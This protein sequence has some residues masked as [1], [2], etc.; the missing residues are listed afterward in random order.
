LD[1]RLLKV[2]AILIVIFGVASSALGVSGLTIIETSISIMQ[3]MRDA[4]STTLDGMDLGVM[5]TILYVTYALTL[6]IGAI[7]VVSGIGIFFR[8]SWARLLW[9]FDLVLMMTWTIY[10]L[11]MSSFNR[12]LTLE[13]ALAN[14]LTLVILGALL[15]YF[16]L[17]RTRS[18]F[19]VN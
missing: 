16:V 1:V 14:G 15:V 2:I 11:T 19:E 9:I 17:P 5:R 12:G 10:S 18:F 8:K 6:V 13:K 3:Q 7:A 4:G